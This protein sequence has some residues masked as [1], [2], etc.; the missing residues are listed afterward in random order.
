MGYRLSFLALE[1][2]VKIQNIE[3]LRFRIGLRG[4]L[5]LPDS[6]PRNEAAQNHEHLA[7]AT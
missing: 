2:S 3:G 5:Q 4:D 6:A 1:P 7:E